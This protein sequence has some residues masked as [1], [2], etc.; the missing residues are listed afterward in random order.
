M[1]ISTKGIR[2]QSVK[3][4]Q[5]FLE[6]DLIV[7]LSALENVNQ[8]IIKACAIPSNKRKPELMLLYNLLSNESI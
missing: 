7:N 2:I 3:A 4:I 6:K 5:I 1:F 8:E